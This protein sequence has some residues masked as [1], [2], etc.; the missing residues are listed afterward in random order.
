MRAQQSPIRAGMLLIL[1]HS[2][3][4]NHQSHLSHNHIID[5]AVKV[6]VNSTVSEIQHTYYCQLSAIQ[7]ESSI[8]SHQED[9]STCY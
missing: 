5:V 1:E 4:Y 9:W 3:I 8:L 7:A 2:H 6:L